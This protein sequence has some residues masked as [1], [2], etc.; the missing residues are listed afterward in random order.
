MTILIDFLHFLASLW[1][2]G[3]LLAALAWLMSS[4]WWPGQGGGEWHD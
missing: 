3:L 1:P 2:Y 4:R